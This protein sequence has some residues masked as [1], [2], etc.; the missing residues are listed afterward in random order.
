M[1]VGVSARF[2]AVAGGSRALQEPSKKLQEGGGGVRKNISGAILG[3]ILGVILGL[4]RASTGYTFGVYI[5]GNIR[6]ILGLYR[7]DVFN[8]GSQCPTIGYLGFG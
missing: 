4:H 5:K 3:C 6:V 2:E 8:E 1:H 7:A